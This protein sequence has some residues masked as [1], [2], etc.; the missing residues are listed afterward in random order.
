MKG[1]SSA[2][3][4]EKDGHTCWAQDM[5]ELI[6]AAEVS[7]DLRRGHDMASYKSLSSF[8]HLLFFPTT[9]HFMLSYHGD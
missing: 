2:D 1:G 8:L 3:D 4:V 6:H 7:K 5:E 9:G